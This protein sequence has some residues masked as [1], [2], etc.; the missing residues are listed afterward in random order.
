MVAWT[1]WAVIQSSSVV[2]GMSVLALVAVGVFVV[3]V[4]PGKCVWIR[5][6]IASR[7]V[8]ASMPLAFC[9]K[10]IGG[11][12]LFKMALAILLVWEGFRHCDVNSCQLVT[13]AA[14]KAFLNL[15]RHSR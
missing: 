8:L 6:C 3:E 12:H 9:V 11:L 14:L 10:Q 7:P 1:S 13:F 2:P 5:F 4:V 15:L